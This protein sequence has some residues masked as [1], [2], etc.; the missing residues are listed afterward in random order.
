MSDRARLRARAATAILFG[1]A[2]CSWTASSL[3]LSGTEILGH[4]EVRYAITARDW[5]AGHAVRWNYVPYGMNLI[6]APGVAA[7]GSP[8]ALRAVSVALGLGFVLAAAHLARRVAGART[9]AWLVATLAGMASIVKRSAELLSDLPSALCLLVAIALLVDET[10][11]DT[12]PR[13]RIVWV[14]PLFA[15][16]FYIRYGTCIPTAVIGVAVAAV[17]WRSIAARPAPAIAT[18]ALLAVLLVPH[19]AMAIRLTGS[20]LG[21]VLES[22]T[23]IGSGFAAALVTYT[24]S[25]PFAYF[26]FTAPVLIVGILSIVR[27]RDRRRVLLWA[28]AILDI[29]ALGLTPSPAVRYIVVGVALLAL[30]GIDAIARAIAAC[31]PRLRAW[32]GALAAVAIVAA[33]IATIIAAN[34]LA[35]TARTRAAHMLLEADAI[36]RDAAGAPCAVIGRHTTQLEWYSGCETVPIATADELRRR[37]IYVVIEAHSDWQPQLASLPSA[38]RIAI[39][40]REDVTVMRLDPP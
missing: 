10:D 38:K 34:R 22:S 19:L 8:H 25:N 12:G 18:V 37:R 1:L 35:S 23:V 13:W 21:I 16:A 32:L 6:A 39:V 26:G 9:A 33:W 27:I 14:A 17:G 28:I 36:R 24:T 15:A 31:T 11:R 40:D 30:L 20:P 4:D 2:L 7:G 5:L 29:V 3:V